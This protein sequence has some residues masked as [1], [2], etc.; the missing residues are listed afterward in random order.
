[1]N[2]LSWNCKGLG[3]PYVG[4]VLSQLVREKA[5]K[6]LFF[7]ET[8]W[9]VGGM[10]K[11]QAELPYDN[12]LAVPCIHRAVGLAMLWKKEITVH[13]QTTLKTISMHIS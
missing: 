4:I 2:V 13:I 10:K 9:T 5:P 8:K 12:M 7:M 3:N 11:I 1:M 6:V